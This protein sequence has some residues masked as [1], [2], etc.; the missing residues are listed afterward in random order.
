MSLSRIEAFKRWGDPDG[1]TKL[2]AGMSPLEIRKAVLDERH[3]HE[4]EKR[5]R[6]RANKR[7]RKK[8]K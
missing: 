4:A 3:K 6:R 1:F 8:R 2:R 7:L 5:R